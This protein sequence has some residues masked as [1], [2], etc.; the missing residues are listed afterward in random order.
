MRSDRE[1]NRFPRNLWLGSLDTQSPPRY[2]ELFIYF[3]RAHNPFII[4]IRRSFLKLSGQTLFFLSQ[5]HK[6]AIKL[7]GLE[8]PRNVF[9]KYFSY[10]RKRQ[11]KADGKNPNAPWFIFFNISCVPASSSVWNSPW[12]NTLF[13]IVICTSCAQDFRKN[14]TEHIKIKMR[15]WTRLYFSTFSYWAVSAFCS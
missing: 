15:E 2:S 13:S 8:S 4:S 14:G 9:H 3:S 12:K 11:T 1:L 6:W 5:Y 7:M 10:L